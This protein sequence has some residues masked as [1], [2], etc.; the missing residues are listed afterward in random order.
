SRDLVIPPKDESS[1]DVADFGQNPYPGLK[2]Y[3]HDMASFYAG[4][5]SQIRDAVHRLSRPGD[6][7]VVLFIT[8]ASGIGKSSFAQAGLLPALEGAYLEQG[9]HV[10]WSVRR[11]G[12][13]PVESLGL[14][15]RDFGVPE[16]Q[17]Q[18]WT[19]RL[20]TSWALNRLL[21]E[22]SS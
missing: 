3:T 20:G 10:R 5:E 15:L 22:T 18:D 13:Y 1:F 16:P 2:A 4:R 11:P 9:R 14:A 6:E 17:N 19:G 8:G 12:R 21:S 7:P